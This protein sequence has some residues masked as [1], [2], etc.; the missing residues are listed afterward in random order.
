M[1]IE[2]LMQKRLR[3]ELQTRC[4]PHESLI[5]PIGHAAHDDP[6]TPAYVAVGCDEKPFKAS[7]LP[8]TSISFTVSNQ[9][10]DWPSESGFDPFLY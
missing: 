5:L 6:T 4:G 10:Q 9:G 7:A 1:S 3:S 2:I 8:F